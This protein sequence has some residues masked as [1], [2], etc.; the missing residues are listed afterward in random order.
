MFKWPTNYPVYTEYT[1][2]RAVQSF[3]TLNYFIHDLLH[4][5]TCHTLSGLRRCTARAI[6]PVNASALLLTS[7]AH[8]EASVCEIVRGLH[9]GFCSCLPVRNYTI[10]RLV[11]ESMHAEVITLDGATGV[12]DAGPPAYIPLISVKFDV[13]GDAEGLLCEASNLYPQHL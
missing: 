8:R 12:F 13:C 2:M 6:G 10:W 4:G 3:H 9:L 5:D 11:H 1:V 7:P